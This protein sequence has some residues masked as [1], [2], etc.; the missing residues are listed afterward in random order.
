MVLAPRST[1]AEP[2]IRRPTPRPRVPAT[3]S[4]LAYHH[5]QPFHLSS[6]PSLLSLW[7]SYRES[8]NGL[9]CELSPPVLAACCMGKVPAISPSRD[10]TFLEQFHHH[11]KVLQIY[12]DIAFTSYTELS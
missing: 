10:V 11:L 8:A 1:D 7:L 3:Y 6:G 5:S 4:L 2:Y 9:L 12:P